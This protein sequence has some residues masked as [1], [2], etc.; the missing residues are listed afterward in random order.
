MAPW[1]K[2]EIIWATTIHYLLLRNNFLTITG[3]WNLITSRGTPLEVS[4]HTNVPRHAGWES[5]S[6]ESTLQT[7]DY[8]SCLVMKSW[9]KYL[10]KSEHFKNRLI[11]VKDCGAR[12]YIKGTYLQFSLC[13][14]HEGFFCLFVYFHT[15][16]EPQFKSNVWFSLINFHYILFIIYLCRVHFVP[17]S[18]VSF[19]FIKRGLPTIL[20]VCEKTVLRCHINKQHF[21]YVISG[22]I[23]KAWLRL[24]FWQFLT[25]T[26]FKT[27]QVNSP[28]FES[29]GQHW[30]SHWQ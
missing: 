20:S 12:Y 5:W 10:Q 4:R 21:D 19:P 3:K 27:Q 28:T 18:T 14:F 24:C 7:W 9:Q 22:M 26:G 13:L 1:K 8:W 29:L 16:V 23:F 17:V 15:S 6:R 30:T 11:E 2:R 25:V